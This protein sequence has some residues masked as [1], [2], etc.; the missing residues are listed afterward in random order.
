MER[1]THQHGIA[2][3]IEA[4]SIQSEVPRLFEGKLSDF[5]IGTNG[6]KSCD[7]EL[8]ETVMSVIDSQMEYSCVLNGRFLG[9]YITRHFGEPS[10]NRHAIQFELSQATYMNEASKLWDDEKASQ[11]QPVFRDILSGIKQ[12]LKTK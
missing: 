1:L 2:V 7:P 10:K 4:H 5:N 9:G 3:L 12:W 6:G 11:V 8:T